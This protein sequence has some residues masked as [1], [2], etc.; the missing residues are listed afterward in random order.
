MNGRFL[1]RWI[2]MFLTVLMF[3]SC[4]PINSLAEEVPDQ[5][6]SVSS[7]LPDDAIL[8]VTE[9]KEETLTATPTA[10][11]KEATPMATPTAEVKEA[12]PI[13]MSTAEV[14]EETPT[15]V[16]TPEVKNETAT[17]EPKEEVKISVT[18]DG[19]TS[20]YA[21]GSKVNLGTP[22]KENY[23]FVGWNIKVGG[24]SLNG[25]IF[26]VP[27][28]GEVVIESMW[29]GVEVSLVIYYVDANGKTLSATD[30]YDLLYGDNVE[31]SSLDGN[32][33][34]P[35]VV[36][37]SPVKAVRRGTSNEIS[38]NGSNDTK[39]FINFVE[40]FNPIVKNEVFNVIY[41]PNEFN[42]TVKYFLENLDGSYTEETSKQVNGKGI[43]GHTI[44]ASSYVGEVFDGFT[45]NHASADSV[46]ITEG[47]NTLEL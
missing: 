25:N 35:S 31:V 32:Y 12:T 22:T 13:A 40:G 41:A 28:D 26:T 46:V 2:S 47:N 6:V 34:L 36:G 27:E 15:A 14:N 4:V 18:V 16:P 30:E 7:E 39:N 3:I 8:N 9:K 23:I 1:K 38:F 44:S 37:Y 29:K 10:E 33:K 24:G 45:Y 43:F 5:I 20:E 17:E 11:V 21:P 19:V 42:Y